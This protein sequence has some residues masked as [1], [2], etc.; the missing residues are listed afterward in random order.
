MTG[1]ERSILG[2]GKF[3]R[4]VKAGRWEYVE[5]TNARAVVGIVAVTDDGH[6][7]LTE[8]FRPPVG[9]PVIELP[10]GLV[11]DESTGSESIEAAARRELLEETGFQ[12]DRLEVLTEGPPSA[13][14]SAEVITLLRAA[15][16]K[17]RGAGGGIDNESITVHAVP[18]DGARRWLDARSRTG[19]LIDPK[20]YAGLYFATQGEP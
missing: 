17:R 15:G 16:L 20:V 9:Q 6:L 5:R 13:G 11:G 8:Q 14:M 18:L 7:I 1:K 3:L 12:A 2:I 4:L 10:A 19:A